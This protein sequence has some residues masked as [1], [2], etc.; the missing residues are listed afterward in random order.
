MSVDVLEMLRP[1]RAKR[2]DQLEELAGKILAGE[3]I[4]AE[5]IDAKLVEARKEP[6]DLQRIIDRKTRAASLVAL[7]KAGVP[8]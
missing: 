6:A 8:A 2:V 4:P 1:V 3:K 7:A 5:I